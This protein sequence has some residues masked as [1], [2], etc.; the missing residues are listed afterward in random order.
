VANGGQLRRKAWVKNPKPGRS[1]V[2]MRHSKVRMYCQ[3]R[4]TVQS[5]T[6]T[7]GGTLTLAC[8]CQ[9]MEAA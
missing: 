9:R 3:T 6:G 7:A 2:Y 4:Q 8:G 1:G 5:V